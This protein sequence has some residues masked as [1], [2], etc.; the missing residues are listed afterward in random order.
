MEDYRYAYLFLSTLF[1]AIWSILFLARADL[2]RPMAVVSLVTAPLGPVSEY[3]YL[4]DYWRPPTLT[5]AAI[6]VEDILFAF[7]LGGVAF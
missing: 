1:A 7:V 6:H 3:W 5:A 4:Q 2:R